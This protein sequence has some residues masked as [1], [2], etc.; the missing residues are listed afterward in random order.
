MQ[1]ISRR[2]LQHIEAKHRQQDLDLVE[3]PLHVGNFRLR[4]PLERWLSA[5]DQFCAARTTNGRDDPAF[6][7]APMRLG[8]V[9][10]L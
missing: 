3:H 8:E 4:Q 9:F 6:Q 10:V 5:V 2:R 7:I 1:L